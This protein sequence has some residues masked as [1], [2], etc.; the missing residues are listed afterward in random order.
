MYRS[1]SP[2]IA[3]AL[4][5]CSR[6]RPV[7]TLCTVF[8][9]GPPTNI[10]CRR[11][12]QQRTPSGQSR[13]PPRPGLNKTQLRRGHVQGIRDLGGS[14]PQFI[15]RRRLQDARAR[16]FYLDRRDPRAY[17]LRGR[18]KVLATNVR[19]V[20]SDAGKSLRLAGAAGSFNHV[21]AVPRSPIVTERKP[22]KVAG[23]LNSKLKAT[24]EPLLNTLAS[25]R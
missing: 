8:P 1:P 2:F 15:H 14:I 4:G 20:A 21:G 25:P 17:I 22:E 10:P 24:A 9:F 19:L 12:S 7:E 18:L 16:T 6:M 23:A 3:T 11:K 13:R 5:A